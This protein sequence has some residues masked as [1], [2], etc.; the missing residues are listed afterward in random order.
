MIKN[1]TTPNVKFSDRFDEQ[2]KNAS[3]G[4]KESFVETLYLFLEDPNHPM[5]RH[6]ALKEKL[7][8]YRSID[9]TEDYQ[10]V[11]KETY[12]AKKRFITFHMIGTHGQLY[13]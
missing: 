12:S 13:G 6:H 7:V 9:V 1:I 2:L 10:A 8:G 11:F 3:D 5:L 4:T